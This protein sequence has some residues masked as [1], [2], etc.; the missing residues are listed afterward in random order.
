MDDCGFAAAKTYSLQIG[1]NQFLQPPACEPVLDR[2]ISRSLRISDRVR[3]SYLVGNS[4]GRG[5]VR[6]SKWQNLAKTN[7][8]SLTVRHKEGG[9]YGC[10]C[11]FF[12]YRGRPY[13]GRPLGHIRDDYSTPACNAS[14]PTTPGFLSRYMVPWSKAGRATCLSVTPREILPQHL[15]TALVACCSLSPGH[16]ACIPWL[17]DFAL[18]DWIANQRTQ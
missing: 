7:L 13:R 17:C 11:G 12:P 2:M 5:Y 3:V 6:D 10:Q 4:V 15:R 8:G 18:G 14:F 1:G 9:Q 16:S